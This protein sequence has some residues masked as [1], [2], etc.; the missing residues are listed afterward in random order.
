LHG[1]SESKTPLHQTT[2]TACR[3]HLSHS[4]FCI[5][6]FILSAGQ[7]VINEVA[8][9]GTGDSQDACGGGIFIELLHTSLSNPESFTLTVDTVQRMTFSTE[10]A[11]D[12]FLLF[13]ILF[14]I[15]PTTVLILS[16]NA[17]A[18]VSTVELTGAGTSTS[19]FQR[20]DN[21]NYAYALKTAGAEN[22]FQD[23]G[24]GGNGDPHFKTWQGDRFDFHGVCDLALLQ[25]K[26]FMSGLGLYVHIRTHLRRD[27]S[28][29]SSA[30]LRIGTDVLEVQS[31]GVYYLNGVLGADLPSDFGGFKF[32]HTQPTKKQHVFEVHLDGRE[33]I[34]IKT[35]K[36]FVN[37]AIEQAQPEHFG[38]SVGLMGAFGT[39]RMIA[40]DGKTI[41]TDTNAFGQEWQVLDSE[42]KLF[43]EARFP[44][45]PQVCTMPPPMQASQLRR[46][47]SESSGAQLAAEKACAHWGQ[48]KD[49]C[50]FD[51]LTTGDLEM[52]VA[53]EY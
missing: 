16:D 28:Y 4:S 3:L 2:R 1:T 35:Y 45:H 22:E 9:V 52:A 39:S 36:V 50:I 13:C 19:S 10:S 21:G 12:G 5:V 37:V 43:R 30:V 41:M 20:R 33:R 48:G 27:M 23:N 24:G 51:V 26:E 25:F 8:D 14:D 53:G 49:D 40:R 18:A 46:R 17:G 44:Q 38:E 42:P 29:I 47:L 6:R 11:P 34:K 32:F 31:K 15:T 7:V